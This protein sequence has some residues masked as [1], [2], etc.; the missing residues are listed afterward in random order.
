MTDLKSH[1]RDILKKVYVI[2]LATVHDGQPWCCNLHAVTDDDLNL[3]WVS[4]LDRRHSKEIADNPHVAAASA[5]QLKKPLLC[6]QVEGTAKL[7]EDQTEIER[8]MKLYGEH[9]NSDKD[10]LNHIVS[11]ENPHRLYRLTPSAIVT[12]DQTTFPDDPYQR[13]QP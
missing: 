8:I 10:W 13:W 4:T 12:F 2:Q 3:Y 1:I 11:G 6:V 7:V 9:H 5:L